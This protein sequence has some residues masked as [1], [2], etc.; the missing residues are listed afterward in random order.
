MHARLRKERRLLMTSAAPKSL[1]LWSAT[2]SH[3]AREPD[4]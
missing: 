4:A 2:S 1:K 3:L